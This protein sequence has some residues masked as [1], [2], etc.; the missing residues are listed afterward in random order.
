MIF[1]A[2][3]VTKTSYTVIVNKDEEL[4]FA[5]FEE[6][7]DYFDDDDGVCSTGVV[8]CDDTEEAIDRLR[9]AQWSYSEGG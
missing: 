6:F 7:L 4:L 5:E 2:E 9:L 3:I 8:D 1:A